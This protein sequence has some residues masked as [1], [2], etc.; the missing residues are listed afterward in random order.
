MLLEI[1]NI[2]SGAVLDFTSGKETA[3]A[4]VIPIDGIADPEA[5][6]TVDGIPAERCD[7]QFHATARLTQRLNTVTVTSSSQYGDLTQKLTLVWDKAAFKRYNFFID[8]HSFFLTDLAHERP[9]HLFDHFYLNALRE[10]NR[11]HGTKFTLN[12]FYRND[13]SPFTMKEMPDCYKAEFEE[14]SDWLRLSFHAFSEF[15]DRPY[16]HASAQ[17]LADDFDLVHSEIARFAGEKTFIPPIV[18]H[19]AMANPEVF[20]VLRERGVRIMEGSFI[21][22]KVY[23]GE[24]DPKFKVCDIGYFYEKDVAS[25]MCAHHA[26]YD[27]F[28]DMLL[29]KSAIVCNLVPLNEITKMI[30]VAIHNPYYNTAV[31]LASHEQYSFPYYNNYLPDHLERLEYACRHMDEAGYK[32]VF[33]AEGLYGNNAWYK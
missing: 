24:P 30:D 6:V 32:P 21:S 8:D 17:K 16:Q 5:N 1:T 28:T 11:R 18:L 15:P 31:C 25:Y 29:F 26:F 27:R 19:W 33:F 13:H 4:L 14:A 22:S 10:I 9:K 12:C 20:P 23:V 3:D 2:R 7:K